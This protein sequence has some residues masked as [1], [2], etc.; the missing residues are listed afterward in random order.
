MVQQQGGDPRT[1]DDPTLLPAAPDRSSVRAESSGFVASMNAEAVGV[2]GMHLGA[3]REKAEDRVDPAVGVLV[4][5]KPGEPVQ[6]G[7]VVF[8]VHHRASRG[9]ESALKLLQASFAV[10]P[11]APEPEPLVWEVLTADSLPTPGS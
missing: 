1:V 6:A 11:Q 7:E 3:G 2:A 9:L 4:R 5:K 10:A 8:E